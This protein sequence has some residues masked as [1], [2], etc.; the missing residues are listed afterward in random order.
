[1]LSGDYMFLCENDRLMPH[2]YVSTVKP[3]LGT[4]S[5]RDQPLYKDQKS[6]DPSPIPTDRMLSCIIEKAILKIDQTKGE[7]TGKMKEVCY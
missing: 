6:K 2:M 7:N 1:M 3:L 4:P 5:R